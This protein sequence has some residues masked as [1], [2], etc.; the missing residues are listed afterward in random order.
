MTPDEICLAAAKGLMP[1]GLDQPGAMLFAT[2]RRVYCDYSDGIIG[3]DTG[4]AEKRKAIAAYSKAKSI[5][6]FMDKWAADSARIH[7]ATESAK[8]EAR[9]NP[10]AET[11]LRLADAIDG[12]RKE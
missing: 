3:R 8:A 12:L 11:A 10:C 4:A 6:D 5:Y 7:R 1:D 2:M 9:K